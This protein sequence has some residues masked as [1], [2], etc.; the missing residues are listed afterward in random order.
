MS[1]ET[2]IRLTPEQK[3][4]IRKLTG[5]EHEAVKV[6]RVMAGTSPLAK[7][8]ALTHKRRA[9]TGKRRALTGKRRALTGK[10]RA[11]TGKRRALTGKRASI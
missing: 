8:Q 9:L 2:T 6:E 1:K 5:E 7:R 3:E 4:Q 11:L 10:R